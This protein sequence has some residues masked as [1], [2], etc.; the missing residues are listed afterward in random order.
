LRLIGKRM[1]IVYGYSV[2]IEEA[3]GKQAFFM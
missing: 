2:A 1:Q 3:V